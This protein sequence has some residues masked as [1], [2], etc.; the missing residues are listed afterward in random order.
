RRLR[1]NFEGDTADSAIALIGFGASA[2]GQWPQGY[3]QNIVPTNDYKRQ[4]AEKG[5]AIAKGVALTPEDRVRAY[6]IER[7][8]CD[9]AVSRSALVA[10]FGR[11]ANIVLGEMQLYY[12]NDG[13][14][15]TVFEGDLFRITEGNRPFVRSVAAA[16]DAYLNAD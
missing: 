8:M 14:G 1:R 3:V 11:D 16:F 2:I 12:E 4:V 13:D 9:F 10:K 5:T 7:L 15:L 6:V